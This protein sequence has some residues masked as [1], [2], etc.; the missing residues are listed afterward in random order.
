MQRNLHDM[1]VDILSLYSGKINMI[2]FAKIGGWMPSATFWYPSHV[3]IAIELL[4]FHFYMKVN[5]YVFSTGVIPG[6]IALFSPSLVHIYKMDW[7]LHI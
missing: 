7:K 5:L 6:V 3:Q 2:R 4:L 1:L